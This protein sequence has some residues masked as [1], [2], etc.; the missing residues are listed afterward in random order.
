MSNID[1]QIDNLRLKTDYLKSD[2]DSRVSLSG[3]LY[4]RAF[5]SGSLSE[6]QEALDHLYT[7]IKLAQNDQQ[8]LRK[9]Y[10]LKAT[11]ELSL[12]RYR[13]AQ[14]SLKLAKNNG[15]TQ[16]ETQSIQADLDWNK[17][18]YSSAIEFYS[19]AAKNSP[20][21]HSIMRL[22]ILKHQLGHF[23][24]ANDLYQKSIS[25]FQGA[26]PVVYSWLLL[27]Y[28]I[29]KLELNQLKKAKVI[30]SKA[31]S[32]CPNYVLV[33]E[34]L[35]ETEAKLA[36]TK[37][38]IE[39]YEKVV[40]LSDNPEF[41]AQLSY[42]YRKLGKSHR[43]HKLL[44][45][46]TKDYQKRVQK[47]PNAMGAHASSFFLENDQKQLALSL[48]KTNLT[49]RPNSESYVALAEVQVKL[50]MLKQAKLNLEKAL[51]MPVV[52]ANLCDLSQELKIEKSLVPNT[53]NS[54]K[55]L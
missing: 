46:A 39:I 44:S 38:S 29:H 22:A 40:Q 24:Q 48:L 49:I 17:G 37:R 50:N 16:L 32:I 26:N 23:K 18:D 11:Q 28:G 4:K 10:L 20:N 6:I 35:G 2:V 47:Y 27:Q 43:A 3:A 14:I 7:A 54:F 25:M 53:C 5:Y 52:S 36:N 15:A 21:M 13:Q 30:F 1:G 45:Q 9:I 31:L 34:H 33:L 41:K 8:M 55:S 12:H 42:Q 51:K 19:L